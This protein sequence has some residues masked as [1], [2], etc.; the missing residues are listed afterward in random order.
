MTGT[1]QCKYLFTF[2]GSYRNTWG[3]GRG[4]CGTGLS[5]APSGQ[6]EGG[7][8]YRNLGIPGTWRPCFPLLVQA[9]DIW[10]N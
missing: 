7:S 4:R 6:L 9:G 10:K 3:R 5:F 8:D 1:G 2:S